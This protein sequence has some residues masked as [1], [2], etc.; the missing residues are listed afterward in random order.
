[1]DDPLLDVRDLRVTFPSEAGAVTAVDGVSFS[2]AAGERL[3]IVGESGAGKSLTAL[4]IMRLIPTPPARISG[5]VRFRGTDLLTLSHKQLRRVRGLRIAMIF[6][7]PVTCL[8]P[9]MTVGDQI[10]EAIRAHEAVSKREARARAIDLLAQVGIP[11]A[12]RRADEYP[13]RLSGGMAQRAMIAMAVSCG[14]ELLLADEPT[15]ALD[16]SIQA[17]IVDLLRSL[18]EERGTAV[19]LITHDLALM[20]R[21]AE[22]IVVLHRG[23]IVEEG[24]VE[25]IYAEPAHPYTM[26]LLEAVNRV[27][28]PRCTRSES[29]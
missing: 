24:P 16:V 17:Q 5:E 4:S 3:G 21:F 8:N 1:M 6:Q 23:R 9:A 12:A 26:G 20:A 14:P 22:R 7:D 11:A 19:V 28:R 18:Y 25:R 15:T 2:I 13:H 29:R 10:V 27:D